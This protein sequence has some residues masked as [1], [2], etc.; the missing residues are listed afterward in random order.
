MRLNSVKAVVLSMGLAIGVGANAQQSLTLTLE[1]AVRIALSE[2]PTVKVADT[3]ITKQEWAKKGTLSSLLP[4]VSFSAGYNRAL[5]KQVMYMGDMGDMFEGGDGGIEVGM[6]NTW[7]AGFSATLPL[8]NAQLWKQLSIS[9]DDV[10]LAVEKSRES[11]ISMVSQV[12]Q[13]YYAVLLAQ[14]S[15]KSLLENL[16]NSQKNYEDIDQKYKQGLKS[17]YDVIRADVAVKNVE[18]NLLDAENSIVLAKWQLKA[19]TGIDLD[20]DITCTGSLDD[21]ADSLCDTYMRIDTTAIAGNSSLRQLDLQERQL[22]KTR[23]VAKAAYYPSLNLSFDYQW[24]A[25]SNDFKFK[26]YKWNPYSTLGL[27]LSIPIFSG[28]NRY[29]TLKQSNIQLQQLELNRQNTQRN[30]MVGVRQYLNSMRTG[31]KQYQSADKS[32]DQARKGY[33]IALKRY[34]TGSGTLLEVND[35]QLALTQAQLNRSQAI[36]TYLVAKAQLDETL[37]SE[38]TNEK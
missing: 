32:V 35:S 25:M 22:E 6:D 26:D 15:H 34:E 3:E 1:D 19:L 27:T 23:D 31:I 8:I 7:A 24:T 30:L 36:Y 5:K 9:A 20:T 38:T 18:P 37:G 10:E 11:R 14:A 2:N 12:R 21:Y 4:Q 17:E 29:S 16:D 13:A 33:D 28:G